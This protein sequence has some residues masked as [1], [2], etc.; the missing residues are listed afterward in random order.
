MPPRIIP[1]RDLQ[2]MLY[3]RMAIPADATLS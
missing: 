1:R 3:K 2:D